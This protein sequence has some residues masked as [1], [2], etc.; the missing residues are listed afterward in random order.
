MYNY[1]EHICIEKNGGND[2]TERQPGIIGQILFYFLSYQ[3]H[4]KALI[5]G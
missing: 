3:P 5:R 2:Q 1:E 4:L